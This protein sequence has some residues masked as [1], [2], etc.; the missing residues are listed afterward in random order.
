MTSGSETKSEET[1]NS[2]VGDSKKKICSSGNKDE[3][4]TSYA[5]A[6]KGKARTTNKR[7]AVIIGDSMIKNINGWELKDKI[8][9]NGIVLVK[10]FNGATI[11]DMD[12]LRY[13]HIS[14]LYFIFESFKEV[15]LRQKP[16]FKRALR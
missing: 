4:L 6:A 3:D 13:F 7:S 1:N 11:R 12:S 15:A 5:A 10:K 9:N 16:F 2:S 14:Y 8:G